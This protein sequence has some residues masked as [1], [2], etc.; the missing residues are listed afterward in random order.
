MLNSGLAIGIIFQNITDLTSIFGIRYSPEMPKRMMT[1]VSM[2]HARF[3]YF[4]AFGL[5][6]LLVSCQ[7]RSTN[8]QESVAEETAFTASPQ[9]VPEQEARPLEPGDEAPEFS[10]AVVSGRIYS[11]AEFADADTLVIIFT[12]NHRP[13]GQADEARMIQFTEEYHDKGVAVVCIMPNS[14]LVLLPEECEYTDLNVA[15]EEMQLG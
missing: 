7:T 1:H 12:C 8:E 15:Y 3:P 13:T 14:I 11:L 6:V 10:L 2:K 9:G 4:F 5:A